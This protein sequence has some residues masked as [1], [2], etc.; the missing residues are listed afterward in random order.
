M[1]V[2]RKPNVISDQ[3]YRSQSLHGNIGRYVQMWPTCT[4]KMKIW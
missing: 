1:H 3:N 4:I 2:L